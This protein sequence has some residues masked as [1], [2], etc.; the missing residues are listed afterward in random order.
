MLQSSNLLTEFKQTP[1]DFKYAPPSSLL[2]SNL[3]EKNAAVPIEENEFFLLEN[4]YYKQNLIGTDR[5]VYTRQAIL[6]RLHQAIKILD[7]K[8]GFV[9][10]D[11][12]RT[13]KTQEAIFY[14]IQDEIKNNNPHL[15][16]EDL[17]TETRKFV[18]H[19][20]EPSRFAI[21]PHN[22]GGSV[23]LTLF[24]LKSQNNLEFGTNFDNTTDLSRTNFFESPFS[25]KYS[26]DKNQW[27]SI[28][29]NR[30][31]LYHTMK[32]LGFVN[33]KSEWWHYSL[34]DCLWAKELRTNWIFDS[35]EEDNQA[36]LDLL[37]SLMGEKDI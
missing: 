15:S 23:D 2:I 20:N 7:Y 10:F 21:A 17:E 8:F 33:F 29:E 16:Q 22:S 6:K 26:F 35:M 18:A 36:R 5:I 9:I 24:N 19:P 28:R 14:R 31:I 4:S 25:P 34:G 1:I 27:T 37:T 13:L 30:R 32:N 3:K 11:A 12:F